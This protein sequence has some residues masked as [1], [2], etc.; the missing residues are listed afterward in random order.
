MKKILIL[1]MIVITL[2]CG[3][4]KK[5]KEDIIDDVVENEEK[6]EELKYIDDNPIK[7]GLYDNVNGTTT[8]IDTHYSTWDRYVDYAVFSTFYTQDKYLNPN[9]VAG[10]FDTYKNNYTSIDN[11]KIGYNI[12]YTVDNGTTFDQIILDANGAN[13]V[14]YTGYLLLYVYDDLF[15]RNDNWYSHIT[16][17]E[18]NDKTMMTSIKITGGHNYD[19]VTSDI[20]LSVFTYNGQEDLD[21]NGKYRGNSKYTV[22]LK[23]I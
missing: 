6:I 12:K 9:S 21:E 5:E 3:C 14:I 4:S 1:F 19:L 23:K 11:Y 16:P 2:T 7:V 8:L 17:E 13:E 10:T 15:H 18:Y 20:E 22:I